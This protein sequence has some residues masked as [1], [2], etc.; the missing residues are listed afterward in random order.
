MGIKKW[1]TALVTGGGCGLGWELACQCAALGLDVVLVG[2]DEGKVVEAAGRLEYELGVTAYAIV[3]DLTEAGAAAKVAS[4][5]RE[6]GLTI[7]VLVNNAGFGYDAS[8]VESDPAR[9]RDLILVNNLALV[10][11]CLEFAPD[12]SARKSGGILNVASVAGFLPG[13]SMAT[14]YA[15]KAFVQSFTQSIHYELR[16][17]GVHVSALCPGPVRTAFWENADAGHTLIS[18]CAI[19]APYVASVGFEALVRNQ[20]VCVPGMLAKSIV[21]ATRI[22]PRSCLAKTAALLQRP[23]RRAKAKA[24][25]AEKRAVVQ[26][27]KAAKVEQKEAA[28]AEKAA[29]KDAVQAEKAA[30]AEAKSAK[31]AEKAAKAEEKSAKKA[32]KAEKKEAAKV[33][34][35]AK[36]AKKAEK[37]N[38][39][40][41]EGVKA[42]GA[43][44]KAAARAEAKPK[45]V[46][47]AES[48]V[49]KEAQDS[50]ETP[51]S[52][53][54]AAVRARR[55]QAF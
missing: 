16:R 48:K 32:A 3:Q 9:Q 14:Y 4:R 31:K 15:S 28:Q 10:E 53:V 26:A 11:M 54:A 2:R 8:F 30:K 43:A 7:D 47:L 22:A 38:A 18:R 41:A 5:V 12:M 42:E 24:V 19:D 51:L 46:K 21:F 29:K 35:E 13:P 52:R 36:A 39:A 6:L 17:R 25:K 50:K 37:K 40:K 1:K 49:A 33:K 23:N 34:K 44:E 45:A 55:A 20:A 27:E